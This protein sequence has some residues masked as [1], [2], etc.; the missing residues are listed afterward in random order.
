MAASTS[1]TPQVALD[2][3]TLPLDFAG[4]F[5]PTFCFLFDFFD[6]FFLSFLDLLVPFFLA[7]FL[8]ADFLLFFLDCFPTAFSD[9]FL[10]AACF[11]LALDT[12]LL[13]SL[14][15]FLLPVKSFLLALAT[16][17]LAS[18]AS[19]AFLLVFFSGFL[20]FLLLFFGLTPDGLAAGSLST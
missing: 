4:F 20:T 12:F 5:L 13:A 9:F 17:L 15:D 3:L 6:F 18:L 19:K 11:L 16:F 10:L 2:C 7:S 8:F 14:E 1:A